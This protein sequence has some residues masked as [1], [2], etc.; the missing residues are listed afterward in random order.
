MG[1]VGEVLWWGQELQGGNVG[2]G[3]GGEVC[4]YRR[5]TGRGFYF[6]ANTDL[7]VPHP[8]FLK[9]AVMYLLHLLTVFTPGS[10]YI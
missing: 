3:T 5:N 2:A 8:S 7:S 9:T 10:Q 4:L 1:W 6:H